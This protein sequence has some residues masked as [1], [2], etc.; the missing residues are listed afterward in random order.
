VGNIKEEEAVAAAGN[1]NDA[2][3]GRGKQRQ[4]E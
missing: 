2:K 1:V 4:V 3:V